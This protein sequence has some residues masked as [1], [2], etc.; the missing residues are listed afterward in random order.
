MNALNFSGE[1]ARTLV[2]TEL[3]VTYRLRRDEFDGVIGFY[4]RLFVAELFEV[5][6]S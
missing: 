3:I 5:H 2:R 1:F 6:R 4:F